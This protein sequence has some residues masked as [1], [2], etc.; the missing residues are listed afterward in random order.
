MMYG[1]TAN[2]KPCHECDRWFKVCAS[3]GVHIKVF[4]TVSDTEIA[5]Y[6]GDP[7]EYKQKSFV[8]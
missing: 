5:E 4:Y 7:C 6:Q 2:A 3:L 1:K 8:W